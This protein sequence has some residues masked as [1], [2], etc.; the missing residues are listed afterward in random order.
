M[1]RKVEVPGELRG[2]VADIIQTCNCTATTA[3]WYYIT[4]YTLEREKPEKMQKL[5]TYSISFVEKVFFICYTHKSTEFFAI[6]DS[7]SLVQ[8]FLKV[9]HIL[10]KQTK[11]F[12]FVRNR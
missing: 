12:L 9:F 10:R 5:S 8:G 1:I 3:I 7:T 11:S 6:I 2:I 4:K